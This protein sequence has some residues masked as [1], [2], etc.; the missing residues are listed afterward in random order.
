MKNF[1]QI[2]TSLSFM[3]LSLIVSGCGEL[4][5]LEPPEIKSPE[6]FEIELGQT[7]ITLVST[8]A[9]E[10]KYTAEKELTDVKIS[11]LPKDVT[12]TIEKA[13]PTSGKIILRSSIGNTAQ[14]SWTTFESNVT[15]KSTEGAIVSQK[16]TLVSE[17]APIFRFQY[18]NEP[19][20]MSDVRKASITILSDKEITDVSLLDHEGLDVELML[21]DDRKSGL[22][23]YKLTSYRQMGDF[24]F[25]DTY[26]LRHI[27][28]SASNAAGTRVDSLVLQKAYLVTDDVYIYNE[29]STEEYAF[30]HGYYV[31]A[32]SNVNYSIKPDEEFNRNFT[33]VQKDGNY[34]ICAEP[35]MTFSARSGSITLTD[36]TGQLSCKCHVLQW[37]SSGSR[38]LDAEAMRALAR[39]NDKKE[40]LTSD[41]AIFAPEGTGIRWQNGRVYELQFYT[42]GKNGMI[43]I[44]DEIGCLDALDRF[45]LVKPYNAKTKPKIASMTK[46]V[47]N[48]RW[49]KYLHFINI[50]L[51]DRTVDFIEPFLILEHLR[52][53]ELSNTGIHGD[54]GFFSRKLW[55]VYIRGSHISGQAP[56]WM[57]E[58]WNEIEDYNYFP[59]KKT[60]EEWAR[61]GFKLEGRKTE[62]VNYEE[63]YQCTVGES[64]MYNQ[65]DNYAIWIG[66]RPDNTRWVDDKFGG[67]WE[68]ILDY[69]PTY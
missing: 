52:S 55:G 57:Q 12:A 44:P 9:S 13:G 67:H 62:M 31:Q 6:T 2:I 21:S 26:N 65:L 22:L 16:I 42:E 66:E 1:L 51:S 56:D 68:W 69:N 24:E 35:N 53:C 14:R 5:R 11:P 30:L 4:G 48:L 27:I 50:D 36:K 34:L 25:Y 32:Y 43:T 17:L 7:E 18:D 23:T 60:A 54:M 49:L 10:L 39:A 63:H 47:K 46:N 29:G 28:L 61:K 45:A 8:Q 20:Y 15:F 41:D 40:W 3:L 64:L 59:D 38:D 19:M 37:G 58:T 33:M